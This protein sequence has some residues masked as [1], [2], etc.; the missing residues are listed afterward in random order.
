MRNPHDAPS[1]QA[2]QALLEGSV[3]RVAT[4]R[5]LTNWHRPSPGARKHFEML[6]DE[7]KQ[8]LAA[9]ET[10]LAEPREG[11]VK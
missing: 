8:A 9:V 10:M 4:I 5:S 11:E 7:L 3:Q 1:M 2:M 6:R